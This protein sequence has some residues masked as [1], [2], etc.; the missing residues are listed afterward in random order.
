MKYYKKENNE[1]LKGTEIATPDGKLY[2]VNI[3]PLETPEGWQ[4]FENDEEAKEKLGI[5]EET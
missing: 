2:D 4:V 3:E 5:V 1:L